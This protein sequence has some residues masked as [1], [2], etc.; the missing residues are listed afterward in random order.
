MR[1]KVNAFRVL[2]L[3]FEEREGLKVKMNLRV[4]GFYGA[5]LIYLGHDMCYGCGLPNSTTK[6]K[7]YFTGELT[8]SQIH[9]LSFCSLG[10]QSLI[11]SISYLGT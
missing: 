11:Q 7:I 10:I 9:S 5:S 6:T 2:A 4:I 3:N 1:A 8:C